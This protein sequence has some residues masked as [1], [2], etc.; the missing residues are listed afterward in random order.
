M[1]LDLKKPLIFLVVVIGIGW[2][3]WANYT[4]QDVLKY[5]HKNLD[6]KWGPMVDYYIGV[7]YLTRSEYEPAVNAFNQLLTDFPT[8]QYTEDGL[9]KMAEAYQAMRKWDDAKAVYQQYNEQFPDGKYKAIV[10]R[11]QDFLRQR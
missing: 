9:L 11:K 1:E 3:L 2:Y 8:T 10:Q 7:G 5:Q 6:P 4:A